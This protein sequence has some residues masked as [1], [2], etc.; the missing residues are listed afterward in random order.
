MA[1]P[2]PSTRPSS[3][4][5]AVRSTLI[6]LRPVSRSLDADG[7]T[8]PD[9]FVRSPGGSDFGGSYRKKRSDDDS[10]ED[11]YSD[12]DDEDIRTEFEAAR[13]NGEA[14]LHLAAQVD[15]KGCGRRLMCEV[16]SKPRNS[17]TEDEILLQEIF[18][19]VSL[20]DQLTLKQLMNE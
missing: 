17:L 12:E 19:F 11:Y 1:R 6:S 20:Y 4:D 14:Y 5:P 3:E 9:W 18:G 7:S 15:D 13:S 8:C 10:D 2:A 16:Y